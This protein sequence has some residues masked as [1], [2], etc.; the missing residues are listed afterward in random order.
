MSDYDQREI[1]PQLWNSF[2]LPKNFNFII[3]THKIKRGS[4]SKTIERSAFMY[5]NYEDCVC[6]VFS[7]SFIALHESILCTLRFFVWTLFVL[8]KDIVFMW[9]A[10][11]L[12]IIKFCSATTLQFLWWKVNEI[13]FNFVNSVL[14]IF[15]GTSLRETLARPFF[16]YWWPNKF[17]FLAYLS[18]LHLAC[19]HGVF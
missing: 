11:T 7:P 4:T 3:I 10:S 2:W 5:I 12:L 1:T 18:L 15:W 19:Y 13:S 8:P 6:S 16:K 9:C 17:L 14:N